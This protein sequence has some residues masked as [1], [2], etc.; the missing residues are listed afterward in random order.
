MNENVLKESFA[1]IINANRNNPNLDF[2]PYCQALQ[3]TITLINDL[4]LQSI[5]CHIKDDTF[6]W[7]FTFKGTNTQAALIWLSDDDLLPK[8][9]IHSN[10]LFTISF[11]I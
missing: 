1:K 10:N 2:Q 7:Y 6:T 4:Q 8:V 5:D 9:T 11:T 3:E